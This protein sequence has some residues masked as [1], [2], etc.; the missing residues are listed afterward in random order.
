MPNAWVP[1]SGWPGGNLLKAAWYPFGPWVWHMIGAQEAV[2]EW[3]GGKSIPG[4][5]WDKAAGQSRAHLLFVQ[6]LHGEMVSGLLV[7][8][9]HHPPEGARAEGLDSFKL[10]QM[11]CI[12][13]AEGLGW[14]WTPVSVACWDDEVWGIPSATSRGGPGVQGE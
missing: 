3:M 1:L 13:C 14:V 7:F 8:Y 11:G 4:S 2:G 10:I 12:L 5:K 6:D 9:Q